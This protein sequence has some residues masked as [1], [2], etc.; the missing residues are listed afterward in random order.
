MGQENTD[1]LGRLIKELCR[2][3]GVGARSAERIALYLL[4][5]PEE[6]VLSLAQIIREI[7]TAVRHCEVCDGLSEAELC[8]ICSDSSR[9]R[10]LICVV[11]LPKDVMRIE[12]TG[13]YK[14][15]YHVLGGHI[16]PLDGVDPD[17]LNVDSLLA[18]ARDEQVKEVI[19]ATNPTI[20]GDG[21]A[22]HICSLLDTINVKVTKLSRGLASGAAIEF[23]NKD[24]IAEAITGRQLFG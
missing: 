12:T 24:T 16:A 1:C 10:S 19:I 4:D 3:P 6:E 9:D 17:K 23:S 2:L 22:L 11:E 21:T 18:R 20:E 13:A 14:G 5:A 8:S 7:K 15:L